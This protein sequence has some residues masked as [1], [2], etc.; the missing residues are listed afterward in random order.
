MMET[1]NIKF[2]RCPTG[3]RAGQPWEKLQSLGPGD[4]FM[5]VDIE[6]CWSDEMSLGFIQRDTFHD[7]TL[8]D[9]LELIEKFYGMKRVFGFTLVFARLEDSPPLVLTTWRAYKPATD[10]YYKAAI[11]N[12]DIQWAIKE[13]RPAGETLRNLRAAERRG[14]Q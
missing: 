7:Y 4:R 13:S 14:R 8:D 9:W 2:S 1:R 5:L 6:Y 10:R 12:P 11:Q 3:P